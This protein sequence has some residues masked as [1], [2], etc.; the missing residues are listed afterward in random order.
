MKLKVKRI[1]RFALEQNINMSDIAKYLG[2][3]RQRISSMLISGEANKG[4]ILSLSK[5]L[6]ISNINLISYPLVS[7]KD[8]QKEILNYLANKPIVL[9]EYKPNKYSFKGVSSIIGCDTKG[10]FIAIHVKK[11]GSEPTENQKKFIN[12]INNSNGLAFVAYSVQDVESKLNK[13]L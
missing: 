4:T 7:K 8:I 11:K 12:S 13:F 5:A 10:R 3:S 2:V 6:G 1:R 9:F